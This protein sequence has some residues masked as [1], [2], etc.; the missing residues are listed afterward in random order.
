MELQRNGASDTAEAPAPS[1]ISTSRAQGHWIP[2][3]KSSILAFSQ[4]RVESPITS[5]PRQSGMSSK[6]A[7]DAVP[8][9]S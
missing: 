6:V 7:S 9:G 8:N 2:L 3:D 1:H 5:W 4:V